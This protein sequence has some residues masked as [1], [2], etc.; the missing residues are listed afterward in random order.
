MSLIYLMG[1]SGS[2]K[3]TLLRQLRNLMQPADAILIAHRYITRVSSADEQSIELSEDDFA[4]RADLGCFALQWRSHGLHYGV[5]I[6]I[7]AWMAAGST[8][9]VNGSR[10]H[11]P[12]AAARYPQL[13]AVQITVDPTVLKSRLLSRGRETPEAIEQRLTRAQQ[14]FTPPAGIQLIELDNN[15]P[16][17]QAAQ[18]L[19]T[20]ARAQTQTQS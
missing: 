11:L 18:T 2:G 16:P 14:T 15:G 8:V 6:E 10:Q 7:D 20:L 19:L 13:M 5:G 4:R 12:I 17:A 9:I 1:A 3:D